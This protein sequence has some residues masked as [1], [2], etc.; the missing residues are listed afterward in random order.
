MWHSRIPRR[1]Y[2]PHFLG[3][4]SNPTINCSICYSAAIMHMLYTKRVI[5]HPLHGEKDVDLTMPICVNNLASIIMNTSDA[6]THHMRQV[7]S[8]YWFGKQQFNRDMPSLW[9][10]M[11]PC[12]NLPTLAQRT[13]KL[14]T[15]GTASPH[16]KLLITRKMEDTIII[17][18]GLNK[19][20]F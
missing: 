18:E 11:E 10:W 1:S 16:S 13:S 3:S 17:K 2:W 4:Q 7:E 12:S 19:V 9:K 14:G 5:S 6:P 8:K 20:Y 15:L